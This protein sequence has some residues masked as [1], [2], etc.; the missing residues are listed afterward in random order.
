MIGLDAGAWTDL[1]RALGVAVLEFLWIGTLLGAVAW[2]A[3]T[4]WRARSAAAKYWTATVAL[5]VSVLVFGWRLYVALPLAESSSGSVSPLPN[6]LDF[7]ALVAV[8]EGPSD[9]PVLVAALWSLGAIAMTARFLAQLVAARRL[10]SRAISEPEPAWLEVFE[11][12][13]KRL[14]LGD[15]VRLVE[16]GLA[17]VP[18]VVGW[19]SPLVLVPTAAFLALPPDHLRALLAHELAH[20]R[21]YDQWVNLLQALAEIVLFFHPVTWWLSR[22]MRTQREFCCD[23]TSVELTG[24]PKIL[25]E[26]LTGMEALRSSHSLLTTAVSS[27]G[28]P[29]MK[30]IVHLLG[31]RTARQRAPIA[32][33]WPAGLL[34]VS[35]LVVG[36]S[37]AAVNGSSTEFDPRQSSQSEPGQ[38][39]DPALDP[40]LG[41]DAVPEPIQL[42]L[43]RTER[44]LR[45]EASPVHPLLSST[46]R[47]L[48]ADPAQQQT[49]E[50]R[51]ERLRRDLD[52]LMLEIRRRVAEG[53]LD[54]EVLMGLSNQ[55][56]PAWKDPRTSSRARRPRSHREAPESPSGR[57][58]DPLHSAESR[59]KGLRREARRKAQRFTDSLDSRDSG[60]RDRAQKSFDR[61]LT[62]LDRAVAQGRLSP[63]DARQKASDFRD[64]LTTAER[65]IREAQAKMVEGYDRIEADLRELMTPKELAELYAK[66]ARR[67]ADQ[68]AFDQAK[69]L[70]ESLQDPRDQAGASW[71]RRDG[72]GRLSLPGT[73][74]PGEFPNREHGLDPE[75]EE[76]SR[77]TLYEELRNQPRENPR[78]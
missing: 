56:K 67:N 57:W 30:R 66:E 31:L 72:F 36:N 68:S 42:E 18:M 6:G 62:T 53:E 77:G 51:A 23:E 70:Y 74:E 47:R 61:A 34:A 29:L 41:Q 1:G 20:V 44:R 49:L 58:M 54:S 39:F 2:L 37:F 24:D 60:W 19:L 35:L 4:P 21:R 25:A 78:R 71:L 73:K 28:G 65:Y 9:L 43:P 10:R 14:N 7:E 52:G 5:G 3:S 13:R 55:T 63:R 12:L 69:G 32:W 75:F 76:G 59:A 17:E 45:S 8:D 50:E 40:R 11:S 15:S 48:D 64:A 27:N 38:G 46:R 22:E 16:S 26:A 33:H